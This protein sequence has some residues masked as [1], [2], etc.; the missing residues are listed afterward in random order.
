MHFSCVPL[1]LLTH[2][3]THTHPHIHS[4]GE[5]HTRAEGNGEWRDTPLTDQ[6]L[7]IYKTQSS[8]PAMTHVTARTAQLEHA[9]LCH[10]VYFW[11]QNH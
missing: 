3:H 1:P 7:S 2:T 11:N 8:G 4:R 10:Q 6:Y 9:L 5:P